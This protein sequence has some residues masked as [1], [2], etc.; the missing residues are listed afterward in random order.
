MSFIAHIFK[1]DRIPILLFLLTFAVM[2]YPLIFR[3]GD[4]LPMDNID[5]H[6][7]MW[8][9]WWVY[10]SLENGYDINHTELLFYPNGLDITLQPRR[11]TTMPIWMPL[12]VLY[13]D[14]LAYN[15]TAMIQIL[16]KAYGMYLFVL[17]LV[18]NR[19]AAW[20]SGAFYA[21]AASSLSHALQQPNTGS[22]EW[23]PWFMLAFA[24]GLEQIHQTSQFHSARKILLLMVLAGALFSASM[25]MNLKVGLFAMLLGG[26]YAGLLTLINGL[27]R[28]P[29]F[30][31]AMLVFGISTLVISAPVLLPPLQSSNLESAIADEVVLQGGINLL[32]YMKADMYHPFNYMQMIASMRDEQLEQL[33]IWGISHLGFVSLACVAMGILYAL[34]VNRRVLIWIVIA[35]VFWSLSLGLEIHYKRKL[36]DIYWTPYRLVENNIIFSILKFPYR[37]TLIFLFPFSVLIGYGLHYRLGNLTLDTK[38]KFALLITIVMLLYGTS[39]FP[40]PNRPEPHPAYLSVLDG[41][42]GA[43]LD[44]PFGRQ[45]AKYYMA[46]Q[47]I[48]NHAIGEG[49][50]ARTPPDAYDYIDNNPLLSLIRQY[51]QETPPED[52]L[53]AVDW[54]ASI[55]EVK[56]DGFVY[57]VLHKVIPQ[58]LSRQETSPTWLLDIFSNYTP[59]YEDDEV[60]IYRMED[61]LVSSEAE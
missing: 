31:L 32:S 19:T 57:L 8:Q 33:A 58:T 48:H 56:D 49:M 2:T 45:N 46:V 23:I 27:W 44:L 30:W 36:I 16:F 40:I 13:G 38:N 5:T 11:W 35:L 55:Q 26:S 24:F 41:E 6:T 60:R 51:R 17:W 20:A 34:R 10:E 28:K 25:Y 1:R 50:I 29:L 37:M 7:A 54:R 18:K 42:K 53:A 21:F 9:N 3:M 15:L 59:I 14:P 61:L 22:T 52:D 12:Y 39:I 43:V 47:R 4:S